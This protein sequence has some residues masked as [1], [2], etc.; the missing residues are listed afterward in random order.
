MSSK[1]EKMEGASVVGAEWKLDAYRR[2]FEKSRERSIKGTTEE[3]GGSQVRDARAGERDTESAVK[4]TARS[5]GSF[6]CNSRAR[7]LDI[8]PILISTDPFLSPLPPARAWVFVCAF[9]PH[10]RVSWRLQRR[11]PAPLHRLSLP[12]H[13]LLPV[14][15]ETMRPV[16]LPKRWTCR[17]TNARPLPLIPSSVSRRLIRRGLSRSIQHSVSALNPDGLRR[18][19]CH[20]QC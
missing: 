7:R 14:V 8:L 2:L 16:S 9:T 1:E 3:R 18:Q 13:R 5:Q 19:A 12:P 4:L 15:L 11:L 10:A 17:S 6:Q 20:L